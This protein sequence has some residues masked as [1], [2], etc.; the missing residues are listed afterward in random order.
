MFGSISQHSLH[1]VRLQFGDRQ[2]PAASVFPFFDDE[3]RTRALML[4]SDLDGRIALVDFQS[5]L[6]AGRSLLP[7]LRLQ[8]IALRHVD[9]RDS[10]TTDGESVAHLWHFD[11]WWELAAERYFNHPA[12][13]AL[14][15]TNLPGYDE[16]ISRVWFDKTLGRVTW[17]GFGEGESMK[18]KRFKPGL[19]APASRERGERS[20]VHGPAARR[21]G[22]WR[23]RPF[24]HGS[25]GAQR[26]R[27]R[28]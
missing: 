15:S 8:R 20:I 4:T 17:V 6:F 11:P 25:R 1:A 7:R 18:V 27:P 2:T 22:E 28:G 10:E 5:S 23:L 26:D 14:K 13:P 16:S 24:W 19:L 21:L 3:G 9:L 12:V